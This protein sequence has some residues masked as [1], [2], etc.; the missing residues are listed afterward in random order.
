MTITS[1]G[2][3]IDLD[4]LGMLKTTVSSESASAGVDAELA[5][6]VAFVAVD[7]ADVATQKQLTFDDLGT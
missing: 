3:N 4:D 5:V 7:L 1:E 2:C 6:T